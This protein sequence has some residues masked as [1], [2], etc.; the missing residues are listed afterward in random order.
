AID[1]VPLVI[2]LLILCSAVAFIIT[3][4]TSYLLSAS[5]NIVSDLIQRSSKRKLSE[6]KLLWY[7]RVIVVIL[8]VL[9]YVLGQF[10]P[11]VLA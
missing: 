8:G 11:S 6:S 5:G 7:N 10:F 2:G 3:T 9:A 4:A 1:G